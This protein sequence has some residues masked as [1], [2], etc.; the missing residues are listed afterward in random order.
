M[1]PT[2]P[3][4]LAGMTLTNIQVAAKELVVSFRDARGDEFHLICSPTG[5]VITPAN[6]GTPFV[7]VTGMKYEMGSGPLSILTA[8]QQ[9][10][11]EAAEILGKQVV[12]T[13][14]HEK[15]ATFGIMCGSYSLIVCP[16]GIK[17]VYTK[18][19]KMEW[20][21]PLVVS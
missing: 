20:R 2:V 10:S 11:G 14:Y 1:N 8:R 16:N 4:S 3:D 17:V 13:N 18:E 7:H 5:N 12:S 6:G 9:I 15:I 21:T 19:L